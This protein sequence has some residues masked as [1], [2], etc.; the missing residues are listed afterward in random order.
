MTAG[1]F[2]FGL[3]TA[4]VVEDFK[5]VVLGFYGVGLETVEVDGTVVVVFDVEE[6]TEGSEGQVPQ[7]RGIFLLWTT[8]G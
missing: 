6:V 1:V 2:C 7:T 3:L 4:D 8:I 5:E